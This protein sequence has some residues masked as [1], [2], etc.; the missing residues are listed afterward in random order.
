[1]LFC[2]INASNTASRSAFTLVSK[3]GPIRHGLL[4]N[5]NIYIVG[6]IDYRWTNIWY[7][8]VLIQSTYNWKKEIIIIAYCMLFI[9]ITI[10]I[11]SS[12]FIKYTRAWTQSRMAAFTKTFLGIFLLFL[13]KDK[14]WRLVR[15][16]MQWS[17]RNLDYNN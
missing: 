6:S 1:M 12:K 13:N 16:A 14:I 2:T 9:Y 5:F 10:K 8:S 7:I 3:S 17:L 15:A 11:L 4:Y